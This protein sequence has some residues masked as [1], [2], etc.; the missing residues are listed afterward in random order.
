MVPDFAALKGLLSPL[1]PTPLVGPGNV[2]IFEDPFQWRP[3][4]FDGCLMEFPV[5]LYMSIYARLYIILLIMAYNSWS[6]HDLKF[7]DV[8]FWCPKTAV[9]TGTHRTN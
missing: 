5:H 1:P 2:P 4:M 6:F 3:N 7:Y 9:T 8:V